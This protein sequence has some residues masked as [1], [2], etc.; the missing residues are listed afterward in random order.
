MPI[1]N[2]LVRD[3]MLEIMDAKGLTYRAHT[4]EPIEFL[5]EVKAKML[6][7]AREFREA[8]TEQEAIEE[9]VDILELVHTAIGVLGVS[10]EE[11]ESS[12]KH[13]K[14]ECGGFDSGIYLIEV[15]EQ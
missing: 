4:L 12:R 8:T 13:K 3:S 14:T 11:L 1:Y 5:T 15:E 6:E 2:K 7:E 9:L 10:Y